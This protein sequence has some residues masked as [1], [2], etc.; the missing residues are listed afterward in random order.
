MIVIFDKRMN[1]KG[2][3]IEHL[4]TYKNSALKIRE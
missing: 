2:R 3:T 4:N 1:I